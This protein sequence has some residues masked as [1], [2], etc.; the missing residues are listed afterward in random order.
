MIWVATVAPVDVHVV[1]TA[2]STCRDKY[3]R[4]VLW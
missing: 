2:L 1:G 4:R 3:C